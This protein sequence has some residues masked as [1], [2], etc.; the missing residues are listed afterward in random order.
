MHANDRIAKQ[1][2]I[3]KVFRD[4]W[5]TNFIAERIELNYLTKP[6]HACK[7]KIEKLNFSKH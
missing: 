4:C 1:I 5:G 3:L 2:M 6:E 7:L